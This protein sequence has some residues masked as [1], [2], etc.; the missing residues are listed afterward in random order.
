MTEIW[1]SR[2]VSADHRWHGGR[3][4]A[5]RCGQH[6]HWGRCRRGTMGEIRR[7]SSFASLTTRALD[8]PT[9]KT[10]SRASR[11]STFKSQSDSYIWAV[12]RRI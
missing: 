12:E 3:G 9:G 10:L 5:D 4:R 11:P 7:K 6:H 2:R 1:Y 8:P